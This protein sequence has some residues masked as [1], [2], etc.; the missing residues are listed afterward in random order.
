MTLNMKPILDRFW[1]QA[2]NTAREA[3]ALDADAQQRAH[4]IAKAEELTR[5][6][7]AALTEL[8]RRVRAL[9][10]Q[11]AARVEQTDAQREQLR[12]VEQHRDERRAEAEG[13]VGIVERERE[14]ARLAEQG[15]RG[16]SLPPGVTP[17][18]PAE[19]TIYP[20]TVPTT[21]APTVAE[22]FPAAPAAE[23]EQTS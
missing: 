15:Q 19:T 6:D 10:T 14:R 11:I 12:D 4:A 2:E 18:G 9:T 17:R 8:E 20:V 23:G 16:D 7:Q 1:A 5:Q 21:P 13:I 22:G 3:Q